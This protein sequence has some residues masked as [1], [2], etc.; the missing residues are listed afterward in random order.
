[1]KG[2]W[3]N[4]FF[5]NWDDPHKLMVTP[6]RG[7]FGLNNVF[8]RAGALL[9]NTPGSAVVNTGASF[10]RRVARSVNYHSPTWSGFSFR[11]MYSAQ[12]EAT[13]LSAST[14]GSKPRM[15]SADVTYRSG[16]LYLGVGY[17]RHK[18]FNPRGTGAPI[19][20]AVAGTA[21]AYSGGTDDSWVFGASYTFGGF[22]R[23]AG[24][25]TRNEW[26]VH[27]TGN[28]KNDGWW[29]IAD[30]TIAGPH[31]LKGQYAKRD[32]AKGNVAGSIGNISSNDVVGGAVTGL[33]TGGKV[34]GI[35]YAY[36]FSK[37]TSGYL[38]VN[39][40]KG[41]TGVVDGTLLGAGSFGTSQTVYGMGFR[42]RF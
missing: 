17:E 26:E 11:G 30:W 1:M 4:F 40:V 15:W 28:L 24:L 16:P 36:E 22:L 35:Q 39:R 25:Y 29:L 23:L 10:S 13:N 7:W 5:G 37:R 12:N 14:L 32:D 33:G 8:A 41:D 18:N 9:W 2:A 20:A 21:S 38:G 6:I 27:N 3:G 34:Y 42:H 31:S 19:A